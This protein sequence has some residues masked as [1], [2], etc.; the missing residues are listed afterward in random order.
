MD[1]EVLKEA[2]YKFTML[3]KL[4]G[5]H[6]VCDFIKFTIENE[7]KSWTVEQWLDFIGHEIMSDD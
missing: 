1:R 6:V 3:K 4:G 7:V 2:I 5:N